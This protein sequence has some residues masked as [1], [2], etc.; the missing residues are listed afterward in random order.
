MS[1]TA[2][3]P[4]EA[5]MWLTNSPTDSAFATNRFGTTAG[6]LEFVEALYRAG[7]AEVLVDTPGVD[8]G[9]EP[10]ADTLLVRLT[11][12]GDTRW[13]VQWFCEREGPDVPAGDF[14]MRIGRDE[15]M[16]WWD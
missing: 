3:P 9:G 12:V 15:I 2:N 1:I 14:V 6:A 4:V 13:E 7:A 10:Y 16:L 5:R 8:S 11:D